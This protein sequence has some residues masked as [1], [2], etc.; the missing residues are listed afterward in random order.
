MPFP[1][2]RSWEVV[3]NYST[4]WFLQC[5][6]PGGY[7]RG[8]IRMDEVNPC[9][10][11]SVSQTML[12]DIRQVIGCGGR[13][14]YAHEDSIVGCASLGFN[15][16]QRVH[17]FTEENCQVRNTGCTLVSSIRETNPQHTRRASTSAR[18]RRSSQE[19]CVSS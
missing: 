2:I 5:A 14:L 7:A 15:D 6:A 1:G 19:P 17:E 10:R 11:W 3:V 8:Y 18:A 16:G 9:P 4:Q 13:E 12:S